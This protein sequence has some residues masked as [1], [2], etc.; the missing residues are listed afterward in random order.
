MIS[1]SMDEI[2]RWF[3][4]QKSDHGVGDK[5]HPVVGKSDKTEKVVTL[6][7]NITTRVAFDI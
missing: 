6:H 2:M 4:Y 7:F 5:D 3:G 1:S